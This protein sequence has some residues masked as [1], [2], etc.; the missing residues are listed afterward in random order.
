MHTPGTNLSF[1]AQGYHALNNQMGGLTTVPILQG[2]DYSPSKYQ[3]YTISFAI[4]DTRR[5]NT[6][7]KRKS[8]Q[9]T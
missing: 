2:S 6:T 8:V 1:S 4:T 7:L 3:L 5:I 9:I